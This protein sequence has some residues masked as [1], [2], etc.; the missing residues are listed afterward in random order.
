MKSIKDIIY[1]NYISNQ[2]F[3]QFLQDKLKKIT[4]P[5]DSNNSPELISKKQ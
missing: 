4:P 5:S 3:K 1:E 2:K